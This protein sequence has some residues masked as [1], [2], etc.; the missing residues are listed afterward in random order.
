MPLWGTILT[1][2][3]S[4]IVAAISIASFLRSFRFATKDNIDELKTEIRN[5]N[6]RIDRHLEKHP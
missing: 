5:I 2:V 4:G 6:Q 1:V 3:F